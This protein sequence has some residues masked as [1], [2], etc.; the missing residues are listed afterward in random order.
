MKLTSNIKNKMYV[1]GRFVMGS[2]GIGILPDSKD[3][4]AAI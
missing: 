1:G 2:I 3:I 4:A